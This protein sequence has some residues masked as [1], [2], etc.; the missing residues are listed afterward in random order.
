MANAKPK[1]APR[2]A[3]LADGTKRRVPAHMTVAEFEAFPFR[4]GDHWELINGET[5]LSPSPQYDHQFVVRTLLIFLDGQMA[6]ADRSEHV[7]PGLDM[8]ASESSSYVW[9][10]LMVVPDDEL[11][12]GK[13]RP[14]TGTPMLVVEVL[15]PSS[16]A[17]DIQDKHDIYERRGVPEYW[18]VDPVTGALFV[19]VR[20]RKGRYEQQPA[21]DEGFVYS[22]FCNLLLRMAKRKRTFDVLTKNRRKGA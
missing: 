5:V 3:V 20:N 4:E 16:H 7:I 15:S 10:D 8:R 2:V 19:F 21:D 12:D 18:V 14:Y 22:S 6:R 9:P 1:S 11:L 17:R 13:A